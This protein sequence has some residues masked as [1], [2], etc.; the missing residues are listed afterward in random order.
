VIAGQELLTL[1]RAAA[2]DYFQPLFAFG[3][4]RLIRF[5]VEVI[6]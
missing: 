4:P 1:F 5:G 6:F 2:Q 3:P